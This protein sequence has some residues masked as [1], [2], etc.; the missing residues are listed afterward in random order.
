MEGTVDLRWADGRR[1]RKYVSTSTQAQVLE[2][3]R[4]A[5]RATEAGV[6]SDDRITVAQFL[7]RWL[8]VK[9]PGGVAENTKDDYADTVRLPSS[10]RSGAGNSPR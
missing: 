1:R 8:R 2:K 7:G 10:R 4:Q 5:Q 6:V 9:L 3:L